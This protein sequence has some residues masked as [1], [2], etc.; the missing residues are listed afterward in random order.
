M[1]DQ[2]NRPVSLLRIDSVVWQAG[3]II[4]IHEPDSGAA[5]TALVEHVTSVGIDPDPAAELAEQ[6]T[7]EM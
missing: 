7:V 5:R 1:S 6:F 2:L 3:Q 4:G